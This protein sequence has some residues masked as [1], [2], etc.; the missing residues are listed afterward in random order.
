MAFKD[1]WL[2]FLADH[3]DQIDK[4]LAKKL[5]NIIVTNG[6]IYNEL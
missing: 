2:M 4:S 5:D 1:Q 3:A 6:D